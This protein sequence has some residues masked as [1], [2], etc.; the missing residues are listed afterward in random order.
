MP[1]T[2]VCGAHQAHFAETHWSLIL[3][4]KREDESGAAAL[5]RLCG[6]YR[7]PLYS[8]LRHRGFNPA[9]AEDITQSFFADLLERGALQQADREK[10]R[11]RSFLLGSLKNFL[12]N[13]WDRRRTLKRGGNCT[14]LSLDEPQ[15]E[16]LYGEL[17]DSRL[18]P[19]KMFDRAWA[20]RFLS[21]TLSKLREEYSH[22]GRLE[23]F[24]A[25]EPTF[26]M[27]GKEVSYAEL[28]N[29]LSL[30]EAATRMAAMR[31]RRRFQKII[32]QE[33]LRTVADPADAEDELRHL[34][35]CL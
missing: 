21:R 9:D 4:A 6:C 24:V 1:T 17:G 20:M 30:T 13:E 15:A 19:E 2:G 35:S 31:M 32:R 18:D 16:V 27:D 33:I 12:A 29:R 25:L 11:F 7:L 14:F 8:Y 28:A 5:N 10:G 22:E 23:L 3:K 34:F 26:S